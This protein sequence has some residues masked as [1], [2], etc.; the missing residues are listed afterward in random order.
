M[1]G[2]LLNYLLFI[3]EK[4]FESF[5]LFTRDTPTTILSR[6]H[7]QLPFDFF[8]FFFFCFFFSF[9]F[10]FLRT[11]P[12]RSPKSNAQTRDDCFA[13]KTTGCAL[14]GGQSM[15]TINPFS[16]IAP[17]LVSSPVIPLT[18]FSYSSSS[19]SSSWSS[20]PLVSSLI[21][22]EEIKIR[23]ELRP[24]EILSPLR[25]MYIDTYIF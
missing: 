24:V 1:C 21:P 20:L 2:R 13:K 8:F 18:R 14:K 11:I 12:T 6:L 9:F 10:L 22:F 23:R 25:Y 16:S 5:P 4:N 15:I 17:S 19:S 7:V 3:I